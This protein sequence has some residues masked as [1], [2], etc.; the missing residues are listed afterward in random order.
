MIRYSEDLSFNYLVFILNIIL[1]LL[2]YLY[3]Y[4]K[5]IGLDKLFLTIFS[6]LF[7][8]YSGFGASFEVVPLYYSFMYNTY[9][10]IFLFFFFYASNF[11]RP[12][13][14]EHKISIIKCNSNL[15][16]FGYIF[17]SFLNAGYPDFRLI[18]L[19]SIQPPNLTFELSDAIDFNQS[20]IKKILSYFLLFIQPFY[21][22]S[23]IKFKNQPL[24]LFFCLFAPI[25]FYYTLG[26]YVARSYLLPYLAIYLFILYNYN[27]KLR[28]Y[29]K[30]GTLLL[31]PSLIIWLYKFSE[32][33]IGHD[34]NISIS[35]TDLFKIIFFQETTYP[36]LFS[37]IYSLNLDNKIIDFF[38]WLFTLPIPSFLKGS[39]VGLE[40]NYY[41]TELLTGKD[42][43]S[44]SLS[45]FL[46]GNVTEAYLIFG[47]YLFF[48]LPVFGGMILGYLYR[49]LSSSNYFTIL[50][51]YF[52]FM[53]VPLVTRAGLNS[54]VPLAINGFLV[55]Y[56]F[57]KLKK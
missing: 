55:F 6:I 46:P 56:L 16:I 21:L 22:V 44:G 52:I 9:F 19:F 50:K 33:R 2:I 13:S 25:Y 3:Y 7:Y 43:T 32:A 24:W 40:I 48:L 4:K 30:Y 23:L 53:M 26:G 54:A 45:V 10:F 20:P 36:I 8:F 47:K 29:I 5:L 31:I 34:V 11:K 37:N 42:K 51:I 38:I 18:K 15:I 27:H 57:L 28:F 12:T 49:I 39:Q 35:F 14:P 1:S 17:F 41:F